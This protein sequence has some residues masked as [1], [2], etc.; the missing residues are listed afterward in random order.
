MNRRSEAKGGDPVR[1][2]VIE[3]RQVGGVEGGDED[4]GEE[5]QAEEEQENGQRNVVKLHQPW[6]PTR[7]EREEYAMTH[8]PFR[9]W[10]EHCVKGRGEEMKHQK[11]REEPEQTEM[12][13]DF[14]FP[15]EETNDKKLT[16]MVVRERRTR[17][18]DR[19]HGCPEQVQRRVHGEAGV[20]FHARN[21]GR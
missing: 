4:R 14:C 16:V 18:T 3:V 1:P 15:G 17:M 8:L 11:G 10:C 13:K 12:H 20:G 21:R 19:E 2:K 6:M 5:V 7:A 9:S